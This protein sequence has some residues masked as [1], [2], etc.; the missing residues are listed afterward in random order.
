MSWSPKIL[1]GDDTVHGPPCLGEFFIIIFICLFALLTYVIFLAIKDNIEDI[2]KIKLTDIPKKAWLASTVIGEHL[3][4]KSNTIREGL[5]YLINNFIR[6]CQSPFI[7][8][9]KY[10][11]IYGFIYAL[12]YLMLFFTTPRESLNLK[13]IAVFS[14][15]ISCL[16]Y[17]HIFLKSLYD[18]FIPKE[19]KDNI[20]NH[21]NV[22]AVAAAAAATQRS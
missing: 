20:K 4:I 1:G 17:I 3:S 10:L 12:T 21:V 9:I 6:F 19:K 22:A 13:S 8:Y 15:F 7:I 2:R 14:L 18:F 5:K 16:C 11:F